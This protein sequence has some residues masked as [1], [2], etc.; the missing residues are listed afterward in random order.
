MLNNEAGKGDR[1]RQEHKEHSLYAE[2]MDL[3][4]KGCRNAGIHVFRGKAKCVY[5][6]KLKDGD[7]DG[8]RNTNNSQAS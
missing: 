1:R 8:T 2:E 5:C 4:H 3:G 6:N 7:T